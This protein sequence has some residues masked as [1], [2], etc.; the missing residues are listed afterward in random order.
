MFAVAD[1]HALTSLSGKGDRSAAIETAR[2][3]L[4]AGVNPK[5][6]VLLLLCHYAVVIGHICYSKGTVL[7]RQSDLAAEHTTMMWLL[8]CSTQTSWLNRMVHYKDKTKL[9]EVRMIWFFQFVVM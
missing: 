3:V 1:L 9:S 4:A 8:A 2:M 6:V 7:Y 5:K